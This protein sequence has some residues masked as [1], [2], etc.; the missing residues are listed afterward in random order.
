MDKFIDISLYTTF[1]LASYAG[2]LVVF[3][4]G[5][6]KNII[7]SINKD[8]N[9]IFVL[10]GGSNIILPNDMTNF[11]I[12]KIE[13]KG[14][15]KLNDPEGKN[16][17]NGA[18]D[19]VFIRV[20]AG[21]VWDDV[22]QYAVD[23]NY[24]GIEALSA[25]PGTAGATPVQNVG[26]YGQEIKDVLVSIDA[27]DTQAGE[28]V[29]ITNTE[30]EFS[31]RMSRFK[32]DW[33]GRYI[34]THIILKLSKNQPKLPDYPGVKKYFEN[35]ILSQPSDGYLGPSL[36]EIRDAIIEI[37]WSKLPKPEEI[38]NCGSFFEN[39]IVD[40]SIADKIKQDYPNMPTF[41][42]SARKDLAEELVKIP[43]GWL[44]ENSGLKG[45]DFGTVG[46]YEK[47]ALVL[48]NLGSATQ[49]D[50]I[51]AR[52]QI[53]SAVYEKFGITLES[54]PEIVK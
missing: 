11:S 16:T 46:T 51:S 12:L 36:Q 49:D 47:N 23:N 33:K 17:S 6:V 54:E 13:N 37:R 39:P 3:K 40:K 8:N 45:A 44:I 34:I 27:Y 30:C 14:I 50:V 19:D 48:I 7:G 32:K 5:D 1:K 25:I 21:E 18:G 28:M 43:A 31:Y 24:S 20:A 52:D 35:K 22:V 4:G 10:G 38:P 9:K 41:H 15:E 42:V 53:I 26:A 2:E 29:S